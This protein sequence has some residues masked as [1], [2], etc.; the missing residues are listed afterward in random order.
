MSTQK[1]KAYDRRRKHSRKDHKT[2]KKNK[3]GLQNPQLVRSLLC[4][5]E[6]RA[7]LASED[8]NS[9]A[10]RITAFASNLVTR[11][12]LLVMRL[13]RRLLALFIPATIVVCTPILIV[14]ILIIGACGAELDAEEKEYNLRALA[15]ATATDAV[16][17]PDAVFVWPA[18][19][20]YYITST[21]GPRWG[22]IHRGLDIG[23]PTGTKIVAGADGNV[24]SA[25]IDASMGNYVLINHGKGMQTY[26]MHNSV[27]VA[28]A[29][30]KVKAG[31]LIAYSGSTG[32]STGPHC[33]FGLK[34]NGTYVNPAPY[35]GLPE[36]VSDGTDVSAI[37][38]GD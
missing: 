10:T 9:F 18:T 35:L 28:T 27:L 15:S 36:N 22:T 29:G 34:I 30:D 24:V 26:Y 8:N 21:F 16:I 19:G 1:R 37:I 7:M 38:T 6:R 14:L 25:G 17:A 23:C 31:Q 11:M 5:T 33:H 13:A 4:E 32:D 12:I 20:Q 2:K 3:H